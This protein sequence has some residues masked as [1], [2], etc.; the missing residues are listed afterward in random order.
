MDGGGKWPRREESTKK[1]KEANERRPAGRAAA[2]PGSRALFS[3]C[4]SASLAPPAWV[5]GATAPPSGRCP[6]KAVR[7]FPLPR[8]SWELGS[9]ESKRSACRKSLCKD[10]T[11][12]G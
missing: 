4:V 6:G 10:L 3:G 12:C 2:D 11:I 8:K 5:G 9:S 1:E 7:A